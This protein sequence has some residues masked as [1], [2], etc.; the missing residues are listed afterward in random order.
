MIPRR[1]LPDTI[2]SNTEV[3]IGDNSIRNWSR[4]RI[5]RLENLLTKD[6]YDKDEVWDI[7]VPVLTDFLTRH[8]NREA[9]ERKE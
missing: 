4:E 2:F 9:N 3:I 8:I 6:G 1:Y 7:A 5:T